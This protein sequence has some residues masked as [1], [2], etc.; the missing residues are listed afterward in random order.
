MLSCHE[1]QIT[2]PLDMLSLDMLNVHVDTEVDNTHEDPAAAHPSGVPA[3][4]HS[5]TQLGPISRSEFSP[6][7]RVSTWPSRVNELGPWENI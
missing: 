3:L 6:S 1:N 2:G 5:I 4:Q 7:R